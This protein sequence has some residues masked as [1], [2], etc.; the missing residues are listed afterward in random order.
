MYQAIKDKM[1]QYNLNAIRIGSSDMFNGN[2]PYNNGAAV[3]WFLDNTNATVVIDRHHTIGTTSLSVAQ[4][5]TI[6]N[7]LAEMAETYESYGDRAQFEPHNEY[8]G[9]TTFYSVMQSIQ[10][11]FRVKGF[12]NW[13]I[14]NRM[15]LSESNP[16]GLDYWGRWKILSD[17][18]NKL[19][20]GSHFYMNKATPT[21]D[22]G[23][24]CFN[25]LDK[26]HTVTGHPMCSTENGADYREISYFNRDNVAAL[27]R[28]MKLSKDAGFDVFAW[29]REG[30]A[31]MPT[32]ENLGIIFPTTSESIEEL[33]QQIADLTTENST[34]KQENETMDMKIQKAILDLS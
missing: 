5:A 15:G 12:K 1:L 32:Y 34:L 33:K 8:G 10:N 7:D 17:P 23:L 14:Y 27:S 9:G 22:F 13:M 26:G 29:Q 19:K 11:T 28:F 21:N 30:L 2:Y 31:N 16:S 4:L 25:A 6:N 3:K 24:Q 20:D 18:L